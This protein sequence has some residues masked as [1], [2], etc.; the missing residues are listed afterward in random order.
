MKSTLFFTQSQELCEDLKNLKGAEV[1][2]HRDPKFC[3]SY[4]S[5]GLNTGPGFQLI[6]I[7]SFTPGENRPETCLQQLAD[8]PGTGSKAGRE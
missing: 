5:S 6:P 8:F 4:Q 2:G 1:Q 7:L 3:T